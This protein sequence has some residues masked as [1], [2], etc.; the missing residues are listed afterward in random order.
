MS[1]LKAH[2][3]NARVY[4]LPGYPAVIFFAPLQH[5]GCVEKWLHAFG[6]EIPHHV[7]VKADNLEN[8]VFYLEKQ[9]IPFAGNIVGNKEA[10]LR[11]VFTAPEVKN[12]RLYTALELTERH[13]GYEGFIAEQMQDLMKTF[14]GNH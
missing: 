6:D 11:Q 3:W 2:C 14:F 1:H 12:D 4:S 8:A 9:G 5:R 13:G 7:A 10:K